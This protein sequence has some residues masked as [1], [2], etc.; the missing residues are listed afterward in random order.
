M[1]DNNSKEILDENYLLNKRKN[2]HR[3]KIF[4]TIRNISFLIGI[5]L[6]FIVLIIL[7]F[8]S[9]YANVYHISIEGNVYLKEEYIKEISG[10]K[11]SDKYLLIMPS[12][13][14]KRLIDSPYIE[15]A[16]VEKLEDNLIKITVNEYKQV[17][18]INEDYS[19]KLLLINGNKIDIDSDNL[20]LIEK[21]PLLEGYTS[22]QI[23][24]ILRGFK[25]IDYKVINEISE[26]HRYPFSFDENMME[27]I[28]KDGNFCFLSWTGTK[29]LEKYYQIVSGIDS[30]L[31]NVCIYLDELTNSG[32]ISACPWQ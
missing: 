4:Y 2:A 29:M 8:N 17:A 19:A 6:A 10:I 18:Y 3:K 31:G 28:M 9:N 26:I 20:Y 16:K 12:I 1:L 15:E 27:V 14:E 30:D 22:E 21:L 32:Y 25:Q 7:Y 11:E 24:E 23:T 5:S 13:V